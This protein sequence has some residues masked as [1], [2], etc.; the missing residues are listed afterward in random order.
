VDERQLEH[1]GA[2]EQVGRIAVHRPDDVDH[3]IAH[4]VDEL[5]RLAAERHV[6][7]ELDLDL[8]AGGLF[9]VLRPGRK[10]PGVCRGHCGKQ[11]VQLERDRLRLRCGGQCRHADRANGDADQVRSKLRHFSLLHLRTVLT[12]R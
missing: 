10:H 5:G 7:I 3:A 8:A 2:R 1:L 4:L 9:H 6:R 11:M 12:R